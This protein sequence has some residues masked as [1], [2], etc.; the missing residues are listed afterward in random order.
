MHKGYKCLDIATGRVYISRDVVFDETI[1]PFSTLNPNAG[2]RL[3]DELLLF[4]KNFHDEDMNS[5]ASNMSDA[6]PESC[7][8]PSVNTG[9][10][11]GA[12]SGESSCSLELPSESGMASGVNTSSEPSVTPLHYMALASSPTDPGSSSPE[13]P[14]APTSSNLSL[15]DSIPQGSPVAAPSAS[16]PPPGSAAQTLPVDVVRRRLPPPPPGPPRPVNGPIRSSLGR[17]RTRLQNDICMP[18]RFTNG[19]IRYGLSSMLHE[20][21]SLQDALSSDHW[22]AAMH[23]EY[24]ALLSNQT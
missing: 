6:S 20:P 14:P 21:S 5:G 18:K 19:T 10:N 2:K 24:D 11:N 9:A 7:E 3:R 23:S 13:L 15:S 1:F 8:L 17:P 12:N 4:P 22:K 16:S